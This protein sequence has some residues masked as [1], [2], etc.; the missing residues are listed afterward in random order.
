MYSSYSPSV[1]LITIFLAT[2]L[3]GQAVVPLDKRFSYVNSGPL[4]EYSV[5]YGDYRPL[6]I[7]TF[8]FM[9]CFQNA[10]PDAFSLSLRMGSRRSESIMLWVWTANRGKPVREN[11]TLAFGA[12]GN[13]VLAD[14]DG[15]IAWQTG[16]ANKGVVGLELLEIGNLVLYDAKGAYIWQS[17]DH[18]SDTLLI[19]QGLHLNGATKLVSRLSYTE[20]ADGPYTL[21]MEQRH[22]AMYYKSKNAANPLLYYKDD[23]FG[24]GKGVLANAVFGVN[25]DAYYTNDLFLAFDMK[26]SL[27]SGTRLL[28][29]PKYNATYS[30]LRLDIDG[31]LRIHTYYPNVDWGAWEVTYEV[32]NREDGVERTSECRLPK[33]CGALGV[34]E[35]NQCVA[36]PT[37]AGLLGWSKSCAPPVL[38]PCKGSRANVDYY[39]VVGVEHFLNGYTEGGR[40]KIGDCR[41]KCSKDCKC[42]GFFYREESSKCL[43]APELGTLIKVSNPAH[44]G[45][46]KMSK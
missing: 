35:D 46:I 23:V 17:F 15:S 7:S 30:M 11:A 3:T 12:D 28:A 9:L 45:Y 37:A 44:V 33:R 20:D 36:C 5:E 14:S 10:T 22:L 16:S 13:L 4:G 19:G 34:C 41:D 1:F 32:L 21:V 39:K 40:M 38:P 31:N 24:D 8:P 42:S 25:S 27:T 6:E 29:R 26:N 2:I 18:P 43:L